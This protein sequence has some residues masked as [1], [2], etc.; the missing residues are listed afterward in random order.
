MMFF[1]QAKKMKDLGLGED[2]TYY[3]VP[4]TLIFN[5]MSVHVHIAI[6]VSHTDKFTLGSG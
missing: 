6:H 4:L 2:S 3:Y 1:D 5:F